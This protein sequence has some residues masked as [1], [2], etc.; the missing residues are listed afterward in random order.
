M[1]G[2]ISHA[3]QLIFD[4]ATESERAE[5]RKKWLI[6]PLLRTRV[7]GINSMKG[8]EMNATSFFIEAI[9]EER[10]ALEDAARSAQ[11]AAEQT[12]MKLIKANEKE[13]A[14]QFA[15]LIDGNVA[16][17]MNG[18]MVFELPNSNYFYSVSLDNGNYLLSVDSTPVEKFAGNGDAVRALAKVLA[19]NP[20]PKPPVT[21]FAQPTTE[22]RLRAS[23]KNFVAALEELRKV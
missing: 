21:P 9:D 15:K 1:S 3:R 19:K 4:A 16:R 22:E 17:V 11:Q 23:I 12:R 14:K 6:E 5:L 2:D 8:S 20:Q 18:E 7:G 13:L 10:E